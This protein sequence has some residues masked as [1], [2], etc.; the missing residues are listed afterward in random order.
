MAN[1]KQ[2]S[3][4]QKVRTNLPPLTRTVLAFIVPLAA[5]VFIGI[6]TGG[7]N[8]GTNLA[9][10]LGALGLASW[11]VGLAFYGLPG[12]GLRGGRP[13]FAGIGFATL[14]WVVFI[15]LR[16]IFIPINP[17]PAESARIFIYLLLFEAFAVQLWLFSLL[18]RSLAD[19]RGP[20]TAATVSGVLFGA[21]AVLLF[22]NVYT[23]GLLT[24][25]YY[26]AWG[27]FYGII[28]LRTGSILGMAL[29]QAMQSFT[30]WTALGPLP[31]DTPAAQLQWVYGLSTALLL[32]FIWR[33]WPKEESDYRL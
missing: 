11:F 26:S 4:K 5:A 6:L 20:L 27:I 3:N 32:L 21:T 28:R 9:P 30:A 17:E 19:W 33:L 29:I 2:I 15:I 31:P 1:K 14:G 12:M 13:L 7:F 22:Q 18:F 25:I 24:L 10:V 23:A 8:G 16:A